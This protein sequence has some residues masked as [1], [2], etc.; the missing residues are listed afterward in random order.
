MWRRWD[1]QIYVSLALAWALFATVTGTNVLG[2]SSGPSAGIFSLGYVFVSAL[3]I[4]KRIPGW[5]RQRVQIAK[6]FNAFVLVVAILFVWIWLFVPIPLFMW[7]ACLTRRPSKTER[8]AIRM[9]R[10]KKRYQ[11]GGSQASPQ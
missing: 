1:T 8:K 7:A 10:I 4:S 9:R 6:W 3:L 2:G 5:Q 11:V